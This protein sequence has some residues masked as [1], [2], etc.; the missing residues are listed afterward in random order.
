MY[1]LLNIDRDDSSLEKYV[2]PKYGNMR[3]P[4]GCA[5]PFKEKTFKGPEKRMDLCKIITARSNEK[6]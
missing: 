6:N 1:S 2:K 5:K 3:L 4:S